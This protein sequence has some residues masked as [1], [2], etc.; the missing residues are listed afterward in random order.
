MTPLPVILNPVAGG[1][2]LLRLRLE[3]DAAAERL[4]ERLEWW[5]TRAPGHATELAGRA[6]AEGRPL[7]LAYG[8]DGT[9][10]E[11]ATGLLGSATAMGVLPG[12]TTSVLAYE[13]GVPRPAPR[14]LSALLAGADRAMR[15]GRTSH[16]RVFL[17][18]LSAGPDAW[19][20]ERLGARLK[21][22]GGRAGVAV[23]ALRELASRRPLPRFSV[24]IAGRTVEAGWAIVG[25]S[26]SYGGPYPAAPG[27]DPFA[28]ELEAIVQT[29][30]G[31]LA[32]VPFALG[33][34]R[35]IHVLRRDVIRLPVDRIALSPAGGERPVPYQ[36]DGDVAGTLPVE[37]RVD[38]E[39]LQMRVP[40]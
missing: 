12:G 4:G 9:Y 23:Q 25:K 10:N 34:P 33:I 37:A 16:G 18:M 2:R 17:L 26:R 38:P 1:G 6:A 40:G 27:A 5:P 14:A 29:S 36:I 11:V 3:L 22:L 35:G 13:L 20:L 32:A 30:T 39:A 8:G 7:V 31:R 19:V 15:V 28:P 24:T 21:R